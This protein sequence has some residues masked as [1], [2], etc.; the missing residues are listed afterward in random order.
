MRLVCDETKRLLGL[1]DRHLVGVVPVSDTG[2]FE[3]AMWSMLGARDVDVF[4]WESFG[5]DWLNDIV[6]DLRLQNVN[7]YEADFGL[8]TDLSS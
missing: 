1:L 5:K 7:I 3:M 4:S 8:L 6:N 2:V